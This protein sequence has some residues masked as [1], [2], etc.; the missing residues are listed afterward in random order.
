M[1]G[2]FDNGV[3]FEITRSKVIK[4]QPHT[5]KLAKLLTS[6]GFYIQQPEKKEKGEK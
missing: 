6:P 5:G 2:F 4:T 3:S 1:A